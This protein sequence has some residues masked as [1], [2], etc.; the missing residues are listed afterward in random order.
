MVMG[1]RSRIMLLVALGLLIATAPLGVMGMGML[2]VATDRVLEERLAMTR[3][4]ADRLDERLAQGWLQLDQLSARAAMLWATA[5]LTPVRA[6]LRVLSPQ[7]SLFSGGIF[8]AD[9]TGRILAQAP[10]SPRLS[11]AVIFDRAMLRALQNG[12]QQ[13]SNVIRV[14]DGAVVVFAVPVF[15]GPYQV[16][17]IVGGV[18]DLTKPTLL[19]FISGLAVGA[20]GHAAIVGR[21]GT[22]V[23]STDNVELFSRNEH[24]EFFTRF[25]AERRPIVGSTREDHGPEVE[26]PMHVMA[27]APVP[28]AHWGLGV[29]QDEEET[30]GPIRRLR[31]RILIFELLVLAAA[32]TFAWLD[33]TA[34]AA[35]LRLLQ[36]AAERIAGGD[37]DRRIDVRRGDEIGMLGRSFEAMRVRLRQTLEENARLQDRLQSVAVLE[38]RERIAREMHDSVGQVLG[39]V[40]T[41]AQAV[42][43]LLE[44]GKIREAQAQLMQMEDIAREVYADLREAILSLRTPSSPGRQLT[45]VVE[46]YVRRFS[47]LS[48]IETRLL[49]SGD[50]GR[51]ALGP[52]TELHLLRI[53]QEALTNVRKHSL[54]RRAWVRFEAEDGRL[55]VS[56]SDDGVGLEAAAARSRAGLGF[57]L[58]TM[59]ERAEA[60]GGT[61]AVRPRE[62]SGTVVEVRVPEH[63]GA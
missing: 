58:Q 34:V 50:P 15:E 22:V 17:G 49:V 24:P 11:A 54:A 40:N 21:D 39:Y 63:A 7:L 25:I 55:T 6:D 2:R 44:A 14:G 59:R 12:L 9:T 38:E 56:V 62:G 19:S 32:L 3:A 18:I 8:L 60:I 10:T 45:A 30:F 20:T 16:R 5:D 29:G 23:A 52:T 1:L 57:G 28:S 53:I 47:D 27:F 43:M 61:L 41:K 37:L 36:G 13:T 31:D 33:T 26:G 42:K 48:G 4:T 35:P 51:S 46:E